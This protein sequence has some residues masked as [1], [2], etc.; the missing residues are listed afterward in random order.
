MKPSNPCE[1]CGLCCRKLIIEIDHVDVVREPRLLPVATLAHGVDSWP[2]EVTGEPIYD[3]KWDR[4]YILARGRGCPMLSD[5]NQ[6]SIYPTRPNVCVQFE[7][8]GE[9]C[10]ELREAAGLPPI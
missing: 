8:G 1:A 3:D 4:E 7:V 5:D 10:N 9:R 2:D 6:C